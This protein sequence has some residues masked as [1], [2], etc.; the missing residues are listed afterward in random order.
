MRSVP[1][2]HWSEG[3]FLRPQ[4]LQ[5]YSRQVSGMVADAWQGMQP[6]F[7]GLVEIEIAEDA[8]GTFTF[9][10]RRL[11]AVLRDGTRVSLPANLE[12]PPRDFKEALNLADGRLAVYFGVPL[13]REGDANTAG[14]TAAAGGQELRY[15]VGTVE[16]ADE[17]LGG[18][19][20]PVEIRRLNGRFFFGEESREGFESL[21][22]AWLQRSGFGAN[23]PALAP[24]FIPP[25]LDIGAWPPLVKIGEEVL[26]RVEAKYRFLRAELTEG[27][28]VLDTEGTGG[29]QPVF[30]LQIVGS[31]LHV[32]R[33]LVGAPGL[34]PF[35]LYFELSRLAGELSI[36]ADESEAEALAVP[37]Y[38]HD[39]LGECFQTLAYTLE[40]LLERIPDH[41]AVL[42]D[43][44]LVDFAD[45]QPLGSSVALLERYPRLFVFR[46]FS[47]AWGLAGL[48]VGY[49]IGGPGSERLFEELAPDLGV[50]EVS[51]AG[52]LEA[53]R[54]CSELVERRVRALAE[55]RPLL[56]AALLERGFEVTE[57]Q[58]NFVWTAHP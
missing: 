45:A 15:R 44:S 40:R 43:E 57:S 13:L 32:L 46:S 50:S 14:P 7:W 2:V 31:F 18:A 49:A 24:T 28:I 54:S 22:V 19:Q 42:L 56:E 41:V 20:Q 16:A 55:E 29:W 5:M 11:K 12:L 1:E 52:A 38:D 10:L 3:M 6:F 35:H 34:H 58:A 33:Q 53:L 36:F 4:H 51:Q 27:R 8:L 47:K 37:L 26:H 17:N 25:V 48:R 39:R 9:S 21:P 23:A 30:K